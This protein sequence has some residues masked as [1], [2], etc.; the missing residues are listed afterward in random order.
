[1]KTNKAICYSL[2]LATFAFS[3]QSCK[4]K[5]KLVKEQ[6]ATTETQPA[7]PPPPPAKLAPAPAPAPAPA[8][9]DYNFTN[10]QFDFNSS[11]LRT[12]A[13]QDLDHIASQMK[14]GTSST[15]MLDGYASAEG[16]A[17][18]NMT[19]SIDR[20]NAVKQYLTNAGIDGS[21]LTAKGHGTKHP[22]ASNKTEAGRE[23]NRRVEVHLVQ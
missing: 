8:K 17:A 6:P 23:Q 1:M 22:I 7:T 5:K 2:I 13:I 21:R 19:L 16:T 11:V 10:V 3:V 12:D 14:L 4:S 18:H 15:F 20:A 9:P